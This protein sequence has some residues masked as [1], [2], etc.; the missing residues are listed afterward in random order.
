VQDQ[1]RTVRLPDNDRTW[2]AFGAKYKVT[3]SA[4]VDFGY[5]HLFIS[6]ASINSTKVASSTLATTVVGTYEGS[7]DILS[8]QYSQSF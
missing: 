3:S 1:Y 4:A 2:L 6:N 8:I 7:V 5:A